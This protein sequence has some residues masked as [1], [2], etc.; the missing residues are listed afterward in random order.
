MQR[1]ELKDLQK[2]YNEESGIH[3]LIFNNKLQFCSNPKNGESVEKL[4]AGM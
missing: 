4:A 1:I 3:L 2:K